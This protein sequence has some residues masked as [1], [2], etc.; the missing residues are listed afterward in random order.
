MGLALV[1][2]AQAAS[3]STVLTTY[4]KVTA[5]GDFQNL[6]CSTSI[7]VAPN[8]GPN[9]LP[10]WVSGE[11]IVEK[12]AGGEIKWWTPDGSH[13]VKEGSVVTALPFADGT[14]FTPFGGGSSN[15]GANG[16][17][18]VRMDAAFNTVAANT[19]VTFNIT[20]D[21]DVFV[22]INGKYVDSNLDGIHGPRFDSFSTNV[23]A[24]NHTFNLF[25]ADRHTVQAVLNVDVK[26]VTLT[27]VPEPGTWALM[28]IGFGGAGAMIRRQRRVTAA[29]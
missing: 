1:A 18:T 29:A 2:G 12:T 19:L 24:G 20:S 15:G 13:V 25:Y 28:I 9:G 10:V 6:C 22:F 4:Y 14:F 26:G 16:F 11:P 23:G 3:A 17:Q 8:L 5:G 21:D 27:A 7:E